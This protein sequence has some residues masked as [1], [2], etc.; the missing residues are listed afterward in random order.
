[1]SIRDRP[2]T[3]CS[4]KA[5]IRLINGLLEK[6]LVAYRLVSISVASARIYNEG[7]RRKVFQA[8]STEGVLKIW[9]DRPRG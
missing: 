9:Q 2:F 7:G 6:D 4:E 3:L 1:M 5:P 8:R